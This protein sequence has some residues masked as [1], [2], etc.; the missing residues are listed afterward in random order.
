[1]KIKKS[2]SVLLMAATLLVVSKTPVHAQQTKKTSAPLAATATNEWLRFRGPNGTGVAEGF[3]LPAEFGSKKNLVW[4][5][6]VPFARSSP[7]V[8]ADRVFLTASEGDKLITLALNRKTGKIL[9]QRE[10]VRA[11]HMPIYRANDAA[12]PSPV[13]D[14]KNVFV[15][16]A[17][18]GLIAY[19]PDGTER[20]RVLLGPFNSFYGMG[21]SPVLASNTLVMV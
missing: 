20:W 19:G 2:I 10:V 17:E 18:L 6:S 15:F 21:G 8:T 5:T 11:R 7:V 14:G 12:S 3:T 4:K 9:W 16:F 13:S 1:M